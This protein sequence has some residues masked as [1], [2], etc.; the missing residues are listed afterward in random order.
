MLQPYIQIGR[1]ARAHGLR[2]EMRVEPFTDDP[3]RF[4]SADALPMV[5]LERGG[6]FE[7]RRVLSARVNG[8]SGA[9][10]ALDGVCDRDG[11]EALRGQWLY[12][13]RDHAAKLDPDADFICDLIG[14]EA[15]DET[16]ALI[17]RLEDVLQPGGNDVYVIKTE[18]GTIL[19]PA[20]KSVVTDVDVSR[21]LV[22]ISR[23][24]MNETAVF[25]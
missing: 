23:E 15:R 2:G 21:R 7:P 16:G 11:A 9:V 3:A 25:D 18:A 10:I 5:Y 13:D 1:V 20:L 19:A 6:A 24:R 17:G 4:G 12:V 22:T 14:C 8:K